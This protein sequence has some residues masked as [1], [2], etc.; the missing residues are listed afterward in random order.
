[1]N[2]TDIDPDHT[3]PIRIS[4][5]ECVQCRA[6]ATVE[7]DRICELCK[8][9]GKSIEPER[10]KLEAG[11]LKSEISIVSVGLFELLR[12]RFFADRAPRT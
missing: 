6:Q 1:M 4:E 2:S 7:P 9:L 3:R 11:R 5:V 8:A 10:Q 12:R